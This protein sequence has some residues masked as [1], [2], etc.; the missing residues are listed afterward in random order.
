MHTETNKHYLDCLA[1]LFNNRMKTFK[2]VSHSFECKSLFLNMR[3]TWGIDSGFIGKH[4]KVVLRVKSL[5]IQSIFYRQEE[6]LLP[7]SLLEMKKSDNTPN[8]LNLSLT[9]LQI[10]HIYI[11]ILKWNFITLLLGYWCLWV[12]KWNFNIAKMQLWTFHEKKYI[13]GWI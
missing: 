3:P 10:I 13:C 6:S 12:S 11:N 5:T 7:R 4:L 1:Y 2:D 9:I 8:L